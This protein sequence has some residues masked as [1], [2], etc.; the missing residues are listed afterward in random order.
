V[1]QPSTVPGVGLRAV[2]QVAYAVGDVAAA[3][4]QWARRTGAGPFLVRHHPSAVAID[5][6]GDAAVFDHSSAYGQWGAVQVELVQVHT[7]TSASLA[8]VVPTAPGLHHV[9]WFTD[10]LR[11]EQRRL[12]ALGWP[13]VMT[14]R[15]AAG[16]YYAFHDA[17]SDLGHL[18]EVYEPTERVR[19][20]YDRVALASHGWD[21]RDVVRPLA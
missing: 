3:A 9:A 4:E 16:H 1:L 18:V 15:T 2:V 6:A 5:A 19:S 20:L 13:L 21:G 12:T 14:A 17:R 8:D 10:D 7:T 11:V